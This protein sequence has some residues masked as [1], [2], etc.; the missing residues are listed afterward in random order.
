MKLNLIRYEAI[1]QIMNANPAVIASLIVLNVILLQIVLNVKQ[2]IILLELQ[3]VAS[4]AQQGQV[5]RIARLLIISM[6]ILLLFFSVKV[7]VRLV[8]FI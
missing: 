7:I 6:K 1:L 5:V 4:N 3:E 8:I 2:P